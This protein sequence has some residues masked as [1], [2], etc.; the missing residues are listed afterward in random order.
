M[1]LINA[2]VK[3]LDGRV[4]SIFQLTSVPATPNNWMFC[5]LD[6]ESK[7]SRVNLF[8][9]VVDRQ[10]NLINSEDYLSFEM[11]TL[12]NKEIYYGQLKLCFQ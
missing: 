2:N 12:S 5:G 3:L 10:K 7:E 4:K 9:S 6:T 11:E 8:S 1:I